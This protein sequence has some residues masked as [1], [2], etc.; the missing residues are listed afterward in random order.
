MV[1]LTP[2]TDAQD[3]PRRVCGKAAVPCYVDV[4]CMG[5]RT[6]RTP[7]QALPGASTG[8]RM[9]HVVVGRSPGPTNRQG[10]AG[11]GSICFCE[12]A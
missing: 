2:L 4:Y 1:L 6:L 8:S 9:P 11:R 12:G 7:S 3:D 10:R 5:G